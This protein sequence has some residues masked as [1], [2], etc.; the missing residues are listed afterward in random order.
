MAH[1][2]EMLTYAENAYAAIIVQLQRW[3]RNNIFLLPNTNK[4]AMAVLESSRWEVTLDKEMD[5]LRPHKAYDLIPITSI[6]PGQKAI[7]SRW[8]SKIMADNSFERRVVVL[9]WG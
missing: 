1:H 7:G 6:P 8:V 4:E 2:M 5:S 3:E 9:V